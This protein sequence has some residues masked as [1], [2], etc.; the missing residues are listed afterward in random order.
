MNSKNWYEQKEFV[1]VSNHAFIVFE[2]ELQ[3]TL[4]FLQSIPCDTVV[5]VDE[6]ILDFYFS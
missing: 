2:E 4:L 6:E 1:P 5:Y 3:D